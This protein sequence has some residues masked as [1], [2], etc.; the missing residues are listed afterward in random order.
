MK[1]H[2]LNLRRRTLL[3]APA[4]WLAA[5]RPAAHAQDAS[6]PSRPV[7]LIG[8]Y[9]P[10]GA[11]DTSARAIA[12]RW[13]ELLG[14]TVIVENRSGGSGSV[15][16]GAVAQAA[17]DGYTL[18]WD[19]PNHAV[20][21][22]LLKGL[23]FDY[24]S[25]FAPISLAVVYPQVIAVRAGLP[26]TDLQGFLAQAKSK[27][28][29]LTVGT[30]GNGSAGHLGLVQLARKSGANLVHVPYRG[31]ADAARD[32]AAGSID[33]V[34]IT[35]HSVKPL[36]DAGRARFIIAAS[37]KRI[38][39][40]P[41]LPTLSESGFPDLVA[42]NWNALLAPARTPDKVLVRLSETLKAALQDPAVQAR[43]DGLGAV[44][45]GNS[46]AEFTPWLREEQRKA[47]ALVREAG[48]T[49]D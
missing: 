2:A 3:A 14:Q 29:G 38:S 8:P 30:Q 5:S 11:G 12:Q 4:L 37:A 20:N 33:A 26:A 47:A 48:I 28:D 39:H 6:W 35:E 24:A 23:A 31:G 13:G 43:L 19:A 44:A 1:N 40:L 36:V 10:G 46:P 22:T 49:A 41:N 9:A 17:P 25:A 42:D 18:L 32:L 34:F 21:G 16:A 7:R 15:G 27:P 45:V